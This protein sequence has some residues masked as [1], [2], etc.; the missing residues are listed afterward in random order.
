VTVTDDDVMWHLRA[1]LRLLDGD[2]RPEVC[3]WREGAQQALAVAED[4]EA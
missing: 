3:R 1:A 4:E 2:T